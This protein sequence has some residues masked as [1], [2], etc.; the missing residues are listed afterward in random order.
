M[1][2]ALVMSS[3]TGNVARVRL[4]N[5]TGIRTAPAAFSSCVMVH[6]I[7]RSPPVQASYGRRNRPR[8]SDPAYATPNQNDTRSQICFRCPSYYR[9]RASRAAGAVRGEES[10][11]DDVIA[12]PSPEREK[13]L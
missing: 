4:A 12:G 10:A 13:W 3:Y 8:G 5:S 7:Y 11:S 2:A 1:G 6:G 9:P